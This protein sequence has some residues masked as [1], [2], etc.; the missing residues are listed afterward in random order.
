[1]FGLGERTADAVLPKCGR[2][3]C[4]YVIGWW[5]ESDKNPGKFIEA[6][7]PDGCYAYHQKDTKPEDANWKE[8]GIASAVLNVTT[9]AAEQG[10]G[11]TPKDPNHVMTLMVYGEKKWDCDRPADVPTRIR[12]AEPVLKKAKRPVTGYVEYRACV[13]GDQ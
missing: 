3:T 12:S 10:G 9:A 8:N 11:L 2:R 6:D 7:A 4:A 13:G 5:D 1:V